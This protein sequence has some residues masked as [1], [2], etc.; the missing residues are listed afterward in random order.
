MGMATRCAAVRQLFGP[1]YYKAG[2]LQAPC[3]AF[4]E[5]PEPR[6][7]KPRLRSGYFL[8]LALMG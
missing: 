6:P 8:I 4:K 7:T 3:S 1:S 2:Q 5:D